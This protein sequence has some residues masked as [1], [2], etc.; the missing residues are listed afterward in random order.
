MSLSRPLIPTEI[1]GS[2]PSSSTGNVAGGSIASARARPAPAVA[3]SATATP[4]HPQH[5]DTTARR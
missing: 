3:S 1:P 2:L 4:I 5:D